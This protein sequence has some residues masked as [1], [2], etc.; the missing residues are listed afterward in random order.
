MK[1]Y[2]LQSLFDLLETKGLL[3]ARNLAEIA[4][5][6]Q[7]NA[8]SKLSIK[9]F[10]LY[11]LIALF[12]ICFLSSLYATDVLDVHHARGQLNLGLLLAL[13]SGSIYYFLRQL[14]HDYFILSVFA[15]RISL[16]S[17][18]LLIL[19]ALHAIPSNGTEMM[20]SKF[21]IFALLSIISYNF[22]QDKWLRFSSVLLLNLYFFIA[23]LPENI[24]HLGLC[25]LSIVTC[26]LFLF[27]KLLRPMLYANIATIVFETINL[28]LTQSIAEV[29]Q[30]H[31][32]L[33]A[34]CHVSLSLLAIAH[35]IMLRKNSLK[36][37]DFPIMVLLI[38][39]SI[40]FGFIS[41]YFT[42][43]FI[44][45]LIGYRTVNE[46]LMLVGAGL[47]IFLVAHS[48]YNAD[49]LLLTKALS[50]MGL[51][52]MLF[53]LKKIVSYYQWHIER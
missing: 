42:L 7:L 14:P 8:E 16:L 45:I 21:G 5:L 10:S 34:L 28:M 37:I 29:Y 19:F 31:F 49:A 38:I 33:F 27:P 13:F 41:P 46:V 30:S 11:S 3:K 44:F 39:S 35:V 20:L 15:Y 2:R 24:T 52:L 4:V 9:L 51:G 17:S 47:L 50:L 1:A 25:F 48:F 40:I 6:C 43:S 22:Y 12:Y 53:L 32:L 18:H 26:A 23:I 36:P